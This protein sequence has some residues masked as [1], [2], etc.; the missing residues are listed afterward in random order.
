MKFHFHFFCKLDNSQVSFHI[1][2]ISFFNNFI[3]S[4]E[5]KKPK[6][7]KENVDLKLKENEDQL[8]DSKDRLGVF[9][10]YSNQSFFYTFRNA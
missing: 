2:G 8:K 5:C 4:L 6:A 1:P 9:L 3:S 10:Y 7:S